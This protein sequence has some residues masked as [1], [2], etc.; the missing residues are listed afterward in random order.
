MIQMPAQNTLEPQGAALIRAALTRDSFTIDRIV[1]RAS[2][3]EIDG[4]YF[5]AALAHLAGG[6]LTLSCG[7][8]AQAVALVDALL[9]GVVRERAHAIS[10]SP[11]STASGDSA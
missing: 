2:E 8:K 5:A 11:A 9:D 7:S 10:Y 4:L 3:D 6:L 1:R